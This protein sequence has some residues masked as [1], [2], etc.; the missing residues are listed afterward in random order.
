[1]DL[2]PT[3]VDPLQADTTELDA[4]QFPDRVGDAC[5]PQPTR[6]GTKIGALHTFATDTSSRW[7]GAG[8]TIAGDRA[9]ASGPAMWQA[10][11]TTPGGSVIA[12]ARF[13]TVTW[14]GAGALS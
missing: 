2:C 1:C 11:T 3:V 12:V 13:S 6:G 8:W 4:L 14:I 9:S 7:L 5:D 10:R